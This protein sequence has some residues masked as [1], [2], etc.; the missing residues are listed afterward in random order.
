M[1]YYPYIELDK[2]KSNTQTE[3]IFNTAFAFLENKHKDFI[4]LGALFIGA[5]SENIT[6]DEL[7][8]DLD[9][10]EETYYRLEKINFNS[11]K[12]TVK[13]FLDYVEEKNYP[14]YYNT[15]TASNYYNNSTILNADHESFTN[16]VYFGSTSATTSMALDN[17]SIVYCNSASPLY[18][19]PI[20]NTDSGFFNVD[21]ITGVNNFTYITLNSTHKSLYKPLSFLTNYAQNS[22]NRKVAKNDK[23]VLQRQ[24]NLLESVISFNDTKCFLSGECITLVSD[25]TG[26]KYRFKLK[27]NPTIKDLNNGRHFST[28]YIL[29]IFDR[30]DIYLSSLCVYIKDTPILD[31]LFAM[32]AYIR[33]GEEKKL[34]ETAN[35]HTLGD[36]NRYNSVREEL[37]FKI[38]SDSR[39]GGNKS[40]AL[41]HEI[42]RT[43]LI[44]KPI[45]PIKEK[46]KMMASNYHLCKLFK[47][48]SEKNLIL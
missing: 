12:N 46:Y 5:M 14:F 3:K 6:E 11:I 13:T 28:P 33:S 29:D 44:S 7:K 8:S 47:N 31:Q 16:C 34:I 39:V 2:D 40:L 43:K 37:G 22:L 36:I 1:K 10:I 23:R 17:G 41:S 25:F 26:I 27:K 48:P 15:S 32:I 35:S 45:S 42:E 30:N 21:N 19:T 18:N 20:N 24:I 38:I 9:I 4:S